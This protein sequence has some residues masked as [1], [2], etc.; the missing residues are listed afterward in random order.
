MIDDYL[1]S[2]SEL[3][4]HAVHLLFSANRWE[5]ASTIE[6]LLNE[7]TTVLCDRYAFSGMAFTF[8]KSRASTAAQERFPYEW[9]R[10]PDAGLPAPDLTLFLDISPGTAKQRGGYGEERYEKEEL[11]R[12]VREVFKR[13]KEDVQASG[14]RWINMDAG[15]DKHAVQDK[16]WNHVKDLADG[17]SDRS[18]KTLWTSSNLRA[19]E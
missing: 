13:I 1:R 16:V 4:D 17:V 19:D 15:Q 8:A 2:Q 11:Q 14:G 6:S 3:D 9:C 18:L 7:G 12:R 10:A 5:L